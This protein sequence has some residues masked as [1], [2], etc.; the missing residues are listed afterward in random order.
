M[1]L[2][3]NGSARTYIFLPLFFIQSSKMF[4]MDH[5]PLPEK[6]GVAYLPTAVAYSVPLTTHFIVVSDVV[7]RTTVPGRIATFATGA[8]CWLEGEVFPF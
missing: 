4:K 8:P 6:A 5:S 1:L 3:K 2:L 7:Q